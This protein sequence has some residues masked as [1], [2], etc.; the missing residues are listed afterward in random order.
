[1]WL[2]YVQVRAGACRGRLP[3]LCSWSYGLLVSFADLGAEN[4]A[5]VFCKNSM[6]PHALS[7]AKPSPALG[8]IILKVQ[9][10]SGS[11]SNLWE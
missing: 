6:H 9:K 10:Y 7:T 5:R 1:M 3:V 4:Q 8:V 11:I 2:G